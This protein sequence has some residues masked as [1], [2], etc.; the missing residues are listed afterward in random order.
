MRHR[1]G[2]LLAALVRARTAAKLTQAEVARPLGTKQ[3]AIAHVEGGEV[4]PSF[5]TVR[6]YAKATGTR[7]TIGLLPADG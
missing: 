3:S 6:R 1:R 4:S 7:L 2:P 5:A